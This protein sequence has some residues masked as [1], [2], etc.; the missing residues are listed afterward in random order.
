[1]RTQRLHAA[2]RP[3]ECGPTNHR[4]CDSFLDDV[5][6]GKQNVGIPE[7]AQVAHAHR[8]E[9]AVEMIAFVLDDAGVESRYLAQNRPALRIESGVTQAREAWHLAAQT[10]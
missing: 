9:N 10:R 1:M 8:I 6:V 3:N 2:P 5:G 4:S 7:Q